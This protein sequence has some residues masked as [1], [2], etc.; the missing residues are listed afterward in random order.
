MG[1]LTFNGGGNFTQTAN[2]TLIIPAQSTNSGGYGK[3]TGAG[4]VTLG[5]ALDGQLT[6]GAAPAVG[7]SFPFLTCGQLSNTFATVLLP[8]GLTVKY[9][10]NSASI[11]V[12]NDVPAILGSL[13]MVTNTF[14]FGFA[15]VSNDLYTVQFATNIAPPIQWTEMTNF[16]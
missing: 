6:Y 7:A 2:G 14:E 11:V 13:T 16:F 10:A 4:N 5:G 9:T 8:Q 12:T 15:M 3:V 1:T